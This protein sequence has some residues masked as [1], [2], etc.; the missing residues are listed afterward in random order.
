LRPDRDALREVAEKTVVLRPP[1]QH[2]ATFGVTTVDYYLVTTPS[3]QGDEEAPT[4]TV[5]REGQINVQRP[6]I[7]T[8]FYLLNLFQGFE[9]G[10][11][12]AEYLAETHGAQSP[13]LLYSYRHDLRDT[14]VVS[15]PPDAVVRRIVGM[16]DDEN[17]ALAAVVFGVDYLWDVSLMKFVFDMTVSSVGQNVQEMAS[18]GLFRMRQGVPQAAHARIAELFDQ[19]RAGDAAPSDLK[20]ELDRWGLWEEYQDRFFDLFRKR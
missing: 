2:L 16:L 20:D 7:V 15:D 10:Q 19:V 14:S 8:P 12:F 18:R 11:Q 3:Y 4:E 1:R 9:H 6:Q 13:G 17:K 5:V